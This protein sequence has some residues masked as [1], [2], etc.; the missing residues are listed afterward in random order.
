MDDVDPWF[1]RAVAAGCTVIR[2][3]RD[4]FYGRMAKV[5]DPYGHVWGFAGPAKGDK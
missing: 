2:P 1:E 3:P 4:E 5:R